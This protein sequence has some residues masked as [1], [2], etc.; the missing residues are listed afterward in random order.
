MMEVVSPCHAFFTEKLFDN[1]SLCQPA[2]T[3]LAGQ[4]EIETQSFSD[5]PDLRSGGGDS[6]TSNPFLGSEA[7]L[8]GSATPGNNR[9][10]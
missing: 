1:G 5:D 3:L 9:A 8:L 10:Q 2:T 6:L 4:R 7:D